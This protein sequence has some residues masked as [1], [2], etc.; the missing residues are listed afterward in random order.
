MPEADPPLHALV[1]LGSYSSPSPKKDRCFEG[2]YIESIS[3][4]PQVNEILETLHNH[5]RRLNSELGRDHCIIG[6]LRDQSASCRPE[7]GSALIPKN[8]RRSRRV[9][10]T[11]DPLKPGLEAY[12]RLCPSPAPR[13]IGSLDVAYTGHPS[14]FPAWAAFAIVGQ[15]ASGFRIAA[16]WPLTWLAGKYLPQSGRRYLY[17]RCGDSASYCRA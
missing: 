13:S 14:V 16:P 8:H 1:P 17:R 3:V 15:L 6:G 2:Q 5:C 11:A 10:C 4:Y 12:P 9:I 7:C